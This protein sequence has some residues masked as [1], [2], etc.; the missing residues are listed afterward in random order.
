MRKPK[1][2]EIWR[3]A[4]VHMAK[5]G[6]ATTKTQGFCSLFKMSS[7]LTFSVLESGSLLATQGKLNGKPFQQVVLFKIEQ[8]M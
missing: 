6:S 8:P 4:E 1:P 7:H 2:K 5:N 3:F